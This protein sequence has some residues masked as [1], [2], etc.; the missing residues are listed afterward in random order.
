MLKHGGGGTFEIPVTVD[1]AREAGSQISAEAPEIKQVREER[2]K[3]F[4]RIN[5]LVQAGLSKILA[6]TLL[7]TRTDGDTTFLART[8]RVPKS[9]AKDLD[10]E[11]KGFIIRLS[12]QNNW[13]DTAEQRIFLPLAEGGWASVPWPAWSKAPWRHPG[14]PTWARP[15]RAWATRPQLS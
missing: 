1:N 7:R 15:P 11:L 4:S 3:T 9:N 5:E 12:T 8:C 6:F 13:T 14:K 10:S 2:R